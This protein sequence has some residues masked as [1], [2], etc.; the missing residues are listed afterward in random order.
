MQSSTSGVK[1]G[2]NHRVNKPNS[3]ANQKCSFDAKQANRL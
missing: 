3:H 2:S 1:N